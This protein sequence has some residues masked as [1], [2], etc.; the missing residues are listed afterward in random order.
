MCFGVH[1]FLG[2]QPI[3]HPL[4]G[5][6]YAQTK[7]GVQITIHAYT[8]THSAARIDFTDSTNHQIFGVEYLYEWVPGCA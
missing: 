3:P 5:F 1:G 2:A 4:Q 6:A 7:P 8:N